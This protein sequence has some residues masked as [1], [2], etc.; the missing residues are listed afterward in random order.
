[1]EQPPPNPPPTQQAG[2]FK[3]RKPAKKI[4]VGGVVPEPVTS[5][6]TTGT[7]QGGRQNRTARHGGRF[8]NGRNAMGRGFGRGSRA[9]IPQGRAFFTAPQVVP[10]GTA[11]NQNR[12]Q[13]PQPMTVTSTDTTANNTTGTTAAPPTIQT[14][15][16][17]KRNDNNNTGVDD[18]EIVGTLEEGVGFSLDIS[19][20]NK[21]SRNENNS[22]GSNATAS[23]LERALLGTG[24]IS[25]VYQGPNGCV[26]DSD[27][28][29]D[30][31][32]IAQNE[33]NGI[34][35][36]NVGVQRPLT[37]PF[38][39]T[40]S[41]KKDGDVASID[42][43]NGN[44]INAG[45]TLETKKSLTFLNTKQDGYFLV[46]LPTRL[47]TGIVTPNSNN[48]DINTGTND[49]HHHSND[50]MGSGSDPEVRIVEPL[51]VA[52]PSSESNAFDNV[53]L[54]HKQPGRIGK[55][56]IYQSGKTILRIDSPN[57]TS[58]P[59][60]IFPLFCDMLYQM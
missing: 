53:L 23:N 6:S 48:T 41:T 57:N 5:T 35:M 4:H 34:T 19:N 26:Y 56:L 47:P 2:K 22:K 60:C 25:Q 3:P 14:Q 32:D 24:K 50:P 44:T 27:S 13:Q 11:A 33:I 43:N 16:R 51:T 37:L 20:E 15:S 10:V 12:Q 59:V 45:T 28:S 9:P 46:Q 49:S 7:Q 55:L 29:T 40:N 31:D 21:S 58:D 36:R 17:R 1:M 18:E 8:G 52:T 42:L 38:S 54:Q 39:S 30:E